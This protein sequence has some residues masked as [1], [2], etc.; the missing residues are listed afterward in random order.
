MSSQMPSISDN[1]PAKLDTIY[2]WM[3]S[4]RPQ[5]LPLACCGI[6]LGSSLAVVAG[7]WRLDVFLFALVTATLLQLIAN[8][9][10]DYGDFMKAADTPARIGPRRGMHLGLI[11][12]TQMKKAIGLTTALAILSGLVL[13]VLACDALQSALFFLGLGGISIVAALT[14]TMG[15]HAYGYHSLGDLSVLIFF[16]WV[17]VLGS[18]YLQTGYIDP[19][20][21]IPATACGLLSVLVLNV[22]NLRDLKE[23]RE[24]GKTTL[25]VRMGMRGARI[26]HAMIVMASLVCLTVSAY[27]WMPARPW[28]WLW[29]LAL[30]LFYRNLAAVLRFMDP[31]EIRAQLAIAV[32]LNII[33]LGGFAAGLWI[34]V[35]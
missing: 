12:P 19:L 27:L 4:L 1:P 6:I 30:P 28:V 18:F 10:N 9:A 16:G 17:S 22:N 14:Y 24:H 3:T 7:H 20:V 33:A 31:A 32:K 34:P 11:L 35:I 8:L 26:Y 5:T 21:S 25:A 2:A 13:M 23:D 29:I 15:R